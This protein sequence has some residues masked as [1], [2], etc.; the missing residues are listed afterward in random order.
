[1]TYRRTLSKKYGTPLIIVGRSDWQ[2]AKIFSR[3]SAK[4]S[5][6]PLAIQ[7]YRSH[8][9]AKMCDSGSQQSR[10]SS[11]EISNAASVAAGVRCQIAMAEHH[12]FRLAGRAGGVENRRQ[13][14]G[15]RLAER[16]A[17]ELLGLV[18]RLRRRRPVIVEQRDER[19]NDLAAA[20]A[21]RS[22]RT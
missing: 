7:V 11:G 14:I 5:C 1:M 18:R 6:D 10:R 3:L 17:L 21:A 4:A 13:I 15:L 19:R 22:D 16:I 8:V 9:R 20:T 2:F 12:P